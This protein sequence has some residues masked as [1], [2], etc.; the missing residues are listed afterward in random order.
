MQKCPSVTLAFPP[1]LSALRAAHLD[2]S[3]AERHVFGPVGVNDHYSGATRVQTLFSLVFRVE[4][5]SPTTPPDA[6]GE[7]VAFLRLSPASDV[8]ATWSWGP[9][10]GQQTLEQ[11]KGLLKAALS[12]LNR[13]P[14]VADA[15]ATLVTDA[16][17]LAFRKWD[18]FP[19]FDTERLAGRWY[20]KFNKL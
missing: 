19:H 18:Y 10:R 7:P 2:L 11:A 5:P 15:M 6:T 16:D 4:S 13:D 1:A 8:A 17:V 3:P 9:Y 12:K 20:E 14:R